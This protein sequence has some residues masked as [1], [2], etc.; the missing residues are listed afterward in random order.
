M[1]FNLDI[2]PKEDETGEDIQPVMPTA[3]EATPRLQD[4]LQDV[5]KHDGMIGWRVTRVSPGE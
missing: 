3:A 5:T 4:I 2:E 1:L